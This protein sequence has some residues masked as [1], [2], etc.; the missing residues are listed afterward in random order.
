MEKNSIPNYRKFSY[1]LISFIF[2]VFVSSYFRLD[3]YQIYFFAILTVTC[4]IGLNFLFQNLYLKLIAIC[5]IIF[6]FGFLLFSFRSTKLDLQKIA[7]GSEIDGLIVSDSV[8]D[9]NNQNFFLVDKNQTKIYVST[10]RFPEYSYGDKIRLKGVIEHP[11][12]FSEFD[13][14]NYLRRYRTTYSTKNPEIE[15]LSGEQ[16]NPVLTWLYKI[17]KKFEE[18]VIKNLPEPESS[19]AI[20]LLVGSKQGFSDSLL[21]EFSKIGITHIIALSGYNVT[22]IIIFLTDILLGYISR[23]K[24]FVLSLLLIILFIL[25]TGAAPSVIRAGIITLLIAYGRTI[26][27]KADMANLILLSATIMVLLNPYILRFDTGFQLSFLAFIGLV[28]FSPVV[29]SF[30]EKPIFK[31]IPAFVR[32]ALTE[33]VSAQAF[34]LPLILSVFGIISVIAPISNILILPIIPATMLFVFLSTLVN[35]LIPTL[36]HLAFLI[37]Y[38]PLKFI[39]AM[40]KLFSA[41]PFSAIN[42]SGTIQ[43]IIIFAYVILVGLILI[44]KNK[45]VRQNN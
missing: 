19:L 34:V 15:K 9:G 27:R 20:G 16:G 1:F 17:R 12:N 22:I 35:W 8:L 45:Y 29:K 39:I 4:L 43:Y 42:L 14:V 44:K 7:N 21:S 33:T 28:Y 23:R 30:L 26:G 6:L 37:A 18:S 11:K 25:M 36:G 13:W 10:S 31:Y 38:L 3:F 41:I 2:G 32:S 24:I 5:S 40:T